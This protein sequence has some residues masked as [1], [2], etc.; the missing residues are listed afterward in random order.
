[1]GESLISRRR[2]EDDGLRVVNSFCKGISPAPFGAIV[3][4]CTSCTF[5]KVRVIRS[6][7]LVL[8]MTYSKGFKSII[9]VATSQQEKAGL[10]G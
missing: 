9:L 1:M 3:K 7:M 10:G 6:I 8:P 2:V 5:L 4:I